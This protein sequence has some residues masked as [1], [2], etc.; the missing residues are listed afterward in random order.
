MK[1]LNKFE[2]KVVWITGAS[3]G[4]G[5][6]LCILL[7]EKKVKG[8]IISSRS[9]EKLLYL[10]QSLPLAPN[11]CYISPLDLNQA[12]FST[13]VREVINHFGNIDILI[14]CGGISQRS[15]FLETTAETFNKIIQTNFTGT[16][17]LTREVLP[18]LL[19]QKSNSAIIVLSS[20]Q[21]KIGI[22]NRT[23]YSASKHAIQG[24]FESLRT[25][26]HKDGLRIMIVSPGYVQTELSKN[27]LTGNGTPNNQVENKASISAKQ[28]ALAI[29][30][31][32]EQNKR[33][34]FPAGIKECTALWLRKFFPSLLFK[35]TRLK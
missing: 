3:S 25:E 35:A 26:L 23:A 14:H 9:R 17:N 20:V 13:E 27:A 28:C 19:K 22:P 32:F 4:I 12:S 33:E 6:A 7:A 2:D 5:Q 21:G 11:D 18:H 15:S 31:G 34:V 30:K 24:F 16:V 10:K 29:I 8:L 1:L